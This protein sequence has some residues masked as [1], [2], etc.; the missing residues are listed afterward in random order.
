MSGIK[1]TEELLNDIENKAKKA[2][3]GSW[4]ADNSHCRG[5]INCGKK[6]IA[7]ASYFNGRRSSVLLDELAM[8]SNG[9]LFE[10]MLDEYEREE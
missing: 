3:R 4:M 7:L 6:H 9:V 1:I 2:T 8:I 5:A 10:A